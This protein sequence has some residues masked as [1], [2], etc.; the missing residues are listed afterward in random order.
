[1][2]TLLNG[3]RSELRYVISARRRREPNR[4]GGVGWG[5]E[6]GGFPEEEEAGK[7]SIPLSSLGI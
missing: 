3:V 2:C 6:G 4:R 7:V 1:M 5:G